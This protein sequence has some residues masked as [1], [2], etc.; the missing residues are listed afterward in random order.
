MLLYTYV[1]K[2]MTEMDR[3]SVRINFRTKDELNFFFIVRIMRI[4]FFFFLLP[5]LILRI[6]SSSSFYT[7]TI[8]YVLYTHT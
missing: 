7:H 5:F 1:I 3:L 8:L 4:I 2:I 6:H